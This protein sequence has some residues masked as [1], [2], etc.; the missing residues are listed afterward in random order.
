MRMCVPVCVSPK[1]WALILFNNNSERC[2]G[3]VL[4]QEESKLEFWN[5]QIIVQCIS[6]YLISPFYEK[7]NKKKKMK[8]NKNKYLC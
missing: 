3:G 8:Q 1:L 7:Q 5:Y 6:A 4:L 2:F